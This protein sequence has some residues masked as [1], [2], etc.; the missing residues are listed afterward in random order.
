MH[1]FDNDGVQDDSPQVFMGPHALERQRTHGSVDEPG[2]V[3]ARNS[4]VLHGFV[5]AVTLA[6]AVLLFLGAMPGEERRLVYE[7]ET[8]STADLCEATGTDGETVTR[9]C[10]ELGTW[11]VDQTGWSVVPVVIALALAAGA[12]FEIYQ[13]P[14]LI[15][16]RRQ[17]RQNAVGRMVE[18]DFKRT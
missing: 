5:A 2:L 6:V 10:S 14:K 17:R 13:L 4:P 12:G 9:A 7:G 15:S 16:S 11:E 8:V 18:R 1:D 3:V